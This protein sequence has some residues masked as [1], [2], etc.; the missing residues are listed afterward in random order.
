MNEVWN[1]LKTLTDPQSILYFGG[2]ALLVFVIF[3]ETGLLIGFFLPGD[4]LVFIAGLFCATKPQYLSDVSFT[5][6]VIYLSAAATAGNLFG[7]W[8][9]KKSGKALFTKDD[10]LRFKKKYIETTRV[11][12]DKHGKKALIA[13]RFLPIIRTF[14]PILAGVIE[15]DFK[16]FMLYNV[17]G[18]VLWIGTISGAGFFLGTRFPQTEKYLGWIVISLIIITAIPVATAWIKN[19]NRSSSK[20]S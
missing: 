13:G 14:A 7:Y 11:F 3:A 1:F 15:I 12:Y 8:F 9:G 10:N 20:N 19:K 6:L 2:I 17:S 5:E 16:K 4:S 18:A